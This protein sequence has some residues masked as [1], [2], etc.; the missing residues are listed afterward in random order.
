MAA[1]P[2]APDRALA[3]LRDLGAEELAH[4]GGTLLAHLRRVQARLAGWQAR[5]ALQLAG[6]CH[7]FYGTDGFPA[8]L[9]SVDRRADLA[10]VIGIEA[11]AL[12]YLYASCDRK[13]TCPLLDRAEAAFHDRFTGL[14]SRPGAQARHD[15]AELSAANELDLADID[16]AF[17]DRW[18]PSLFALF[19][20]WHNLLSA[21]AWLDCRR[22]LGGPARPPAD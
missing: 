22:V 13:A 18:G 15:F 11:E 5:P 10:A 6:L 19:G 4:P 21:R 16:P 17:R 3:L 7:A 8:A 2:T 20:R 1:P 9:L 14:A 12:V